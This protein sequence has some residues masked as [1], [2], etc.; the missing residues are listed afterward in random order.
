MYNFLKD[1]LH[2]HHLPYDL[3]L[4]Q[5]KMIV[6]QKTTHFAKKPKI[7]ATALKQEC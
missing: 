1:K 3:I 6:K 7:L 4:I 2:R 5:I